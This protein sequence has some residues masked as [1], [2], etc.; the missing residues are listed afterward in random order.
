MFDDM[1]TDKVKVCW[2]RTWST[3]LV[4]KYDNHMEYGR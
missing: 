2:H 1:H 3:R 4:E